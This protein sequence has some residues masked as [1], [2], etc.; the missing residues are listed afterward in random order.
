MRR[1]MGTLDRA[2]R[3]LTGV[4]LLAWGF[5]AGL[6]AWEVP[7]LVIG[8]VLGLTAPTGFC[9][10]YLPFHIDTRGRG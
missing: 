2:L 8:G 4:M 3:G 6:G 10:L 1:N 9:P 7:V 5:T